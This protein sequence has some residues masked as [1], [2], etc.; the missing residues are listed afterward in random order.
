MDTHTEQALPPIEPTRRGFIKWL[1]GFSV[2]GTLAGVLVPIIG[3]LWPPARKGLGYTGP[4]MV[5]ALVDLPVGTGK[6]VPVDN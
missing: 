5:G 6:V 2:V 3:Y 1:L 4:T